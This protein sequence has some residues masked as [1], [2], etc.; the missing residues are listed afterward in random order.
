MSTGFRSAALLAC[1]LSL[2]PLA[3]AAAQG[4]TG[5][6]I[7]GRVLN[8]IGDSGVVVTVT[9]TDLRTGQRLDRETLSDGRFRFDGL[10]PGGPYALQ[11]RLPGY[12]PAEATGIILTLGQRVQVVLRVAPEAVPLESI[13]VV[14][15]P[16]RALARARSGPWFVVSDSAV[17]RLPTVNRDFVGLVQAAPEVNGTSI[18][19]ANNRY[20]NIQI[21]GG[22]DNDY[23]G[24]SRG[25]GAPGGQIGV[26]S[27]PLEA[28][29]EFQVQV[30]PFDVTQGDFLGGRITA[31][32]QSGT[33]TFHGSLFN[34]YQAADLTG[35]D[36][37]GLRASDFSDWQFGAALG[38]PVIRDRLHFFLAGEMRRR[39]APFTGPAIGR[40]SGAGISTDSVTRF[41]SILRGYGLDPGSFDPYTTHD[42]N[43]NLFAKL[44]AA[45][46]TSGTLEGSLNYS[47]GSITDTLAPPRTVGGDYRLTSAGF[48]PNSTQWSGRLRW[49]SVLGR[50]ATNEALAGYLHVSEPR[51]PAASYPGIFV[52]GVGDSG[53]AGARLV[54]GGDPSSQ[55]LELTQRAIELSNA[56][57]LDFGRHVFLAG[58]HAEFLHFDFASLPSAIGQYQFTSLGALEA[59]T[60][61]RFIR[62]IALRPGGAEA[63]F[64]ASWLGF[65]AQDRMELAP[66]LALTAGLR[67]DLPFLPTTPEPNTTLRASPLGV[68]TAEFIDTRALWSPR[69]GINWAVRPAT[70]VRGG[71]GLFAGPIPY[72]WLSFAY[73]QTGNDA[74]TLSCSGAAAP[75]FNPDPA[76]QPT[77]CLT[78][79]APAIPTVTYVAPDLRMPR[80]FKLTLGADQALPGGFVASLDGLYQ[81]GINSPYLTDVNLT[82]PVGTLAGE[83][84]RVLYGTIAATSAAGALPSVTPSRV[85]TA[86]GPV[87]RISN[88]GGDRI[89]LMTAQVRRRFS[90]RLELNAAYTYTDAKDLMSLR[91]AQTVSNY[92]FVPL[93][94]TP[95]DRRLATSVF[96]TPHK[97]TLSGTVNLPYD[98]SFTLIYLGSSGTPFTYV[99]N[100]DANGDGVGNL[101]G[102]FDR[103]ANDPVYLPKNAGDISLVRDSASTLVPDPAGVAKLQKFIQGESCLQNAQGSILPRNAC[104]NPWQSVLNARLAKRVG[105][106]GGRGLELSLDVFNLLHLIDGDWG[107]IRQTGTLAGAGTENVPML[108]L[109]GQDTANGRNLYQLTLPAREAINVEASRW[110]MQLGARYAF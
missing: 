3:K 49:N 77:A 59:G 46:G 71:A 7:E 94:G 101:S 38:G 41:V 1:A 70:T 10:T 52:T 28:V 83:G 48:A 15:H 16:E 60:P 106:G 95:G 44:S 61:S 40:G 105:L 54:A 93:M 100:G 13:T 104:R 92:G 110:R 67:M 33:N 39:N 88:R 24:L 63:A 68:N 74:V 20:N 35:R 22:A 86:F 90:A 87:L 4:P 17:R 72:S 107:L 78:A 76:T 23:F 51:D 12:R 64:Y 32:T 34:Y 65:Y 99:V 82:G 18:A 50:R 62:G 2:C 80:V 56:T 57:T 11:A 30:A 81:R 75:H 31:V 43:G 36:T 69:L 25:T 37:T 5:A 108:K 47:D 91:D 73:T 9:L 84:G 21:D 6:A 96:S 97:I 14:G 85:T 19:S 45:V 26:R 27:L 98:A 58:V 53:F 103:Q 102:A 42:R 109:R 66:G 8:L 79:G 55:K 89:W 29:R